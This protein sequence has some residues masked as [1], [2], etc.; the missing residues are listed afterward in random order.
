MRNLTSTL[1]F[2]LILNACGPT[3]EPNSWQSEPLQPAPPSSQGF[4]EVKIQKLDELFQSNIEEGNIAGATALVA[5]QGKI[6]YYQSTGYND[7]EN[8]IPLEKDA[9]F[10][11]ASQTKGITSV[12]IMRL[13]EE[14]KLELQDPVSKHLAEFSYPELIDQFNVKD[15]SYISRPAKREVTIQDL[16]T[17]TSGYA[18]PGN[19]GDEGNAI[20]ARAGIMSGVPIKS[21]TLKDE[22][23]KISKLPLIHEPGEKFTYG[24]STDILG[25]VVEVLSGKNLAE[26]FRS[27]IFDPLGMEDTYF[28]L[29]KEKHARLMNLYLES[30]GNIGL[31][32]A[33]ETMAGYPKNTNLYYSGGGGLSSTAMDYAIFIQMLLNQ[34]EYKGV[35]L[36]KPET[37]Q[38]MRR[39]HIGE[40]GAGSLFLPDTPDKFGLGFEVMFPSEADSMQITEGSFGW[41]GAFGSLYWIDPEEELI[42]HLVIQKAGDYAQLRYDFINAVYRALKTESIESR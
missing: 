1:L 35:R 17:H 30:P 20:Y 11:I 28:H 39:N 15:S 26:Y 3:Q 23:Q 18:Y 4:S 16:L 10:R 7:L 32:K 2:G 33:P 31:S 24:L 40:L 13:Y 6:V 12:A 8:R 25:Y 41:G 37:V 14:G 42:A 19:G 29:P 9:I 21:S 22:M 27:E 5:R 34:G 36:L 38:L